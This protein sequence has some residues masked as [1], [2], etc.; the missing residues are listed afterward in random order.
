M[1]ESSTP[2]VARRQA[3]TTLWLALAC[4]AGVAMAVTFGFRRTPGSD[5]ARFSSPASPDALG[6][7]PVLWD[8]PEFALVDPHGTRVTKSLL[9][10]H[11]W[12]ADFIYTRCTSVCPMLTARMRLIQ[13]ELTGA[14]FRFVSF[15][16]DPKN[17][18]ADALRRYAD[19]WGKDERRWFLLRTEPE[20][21]QRLTDGMRVVTEATRDEASPILHT[22]LFFLVDTA[23]RVRGLYDSDDDG[24][25]HRLIADARRLSPGPPPPSE[26][27]RASVRSGKARFEELGCAGCHDDAKLA[28]SL[29]GIWGREVLL[30]DGTRVQ[31]DATYVRESITLPAARLVY[32]YLNSMPSYASALS[33]T[34]IDD[35]VDYVQSLS[36]PASSSA[37]PLTR[38]ATRVETRAGAAVAR[39]TFGESRDA[40]SLEPVSFA[41]PSGAQRDPI[42]GMSVRVTLE[43]P[44]A[45]RDGQ[46]YYFCSD[47]CRAKFLGVKSDPQKAARE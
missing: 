8:V 34:Q 40:A 1:H 13:R 18:T 32:D 12:I 33:A 26:A 45:T 41:A 30:A 37:A 2:T 23:G 35:L 27:A 10:K 3:R 16:V 7:L 9:D 15:S 14:D 38:A 28:P 36:T 29:R 5:A 4:V 46:Q 6:R 42:C 43:T 24:A 39:E 31:V 11:V 47:D 17:D 19:I 25:L 44:H 20:S 21:L 22:S